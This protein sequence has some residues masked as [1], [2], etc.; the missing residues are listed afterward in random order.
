MNAAIL[1]VGALA[2]SDAP[3]VEADATVEDVTEL[4]GTWEVV[5]VVIDGIDQSK[6]YQGDHWTFAGDTV[7]WPGGRRHFAAFKA[8]LDLIDEFRVCPG[9]YRLDHNTLIWTLHLGS[10]PFRMT[11]RRVSQ[12]G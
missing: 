5:E 4:Q 2:T 6:L 7:K 12:G 9:V 11:F 1:L 10:L 3:A 8:G